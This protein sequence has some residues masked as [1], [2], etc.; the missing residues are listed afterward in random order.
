MLST[1]ELTGIV[2]KPGNILLKRLTVFYGTA[3]DSGYKL[4][5]TLTKRH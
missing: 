4:L 5:T 2:G 3:E 1:E